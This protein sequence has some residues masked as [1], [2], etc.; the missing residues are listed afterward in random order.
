VGDRIGRYGQGGKAA[1]GHLGNLFDIVASAAGASAT[2]APARKSAPL[3]ALN[4]LVGEVELRHVPVTLN[5]ADVDRG[6]EA[7]AAVE[8]RLRALLAPAVRRFTREPAS[9]VTPEVERTAEQVRRIPARALRLLEEGRL[10]ESEV[11]AGC[12]GRGSGPDR[13]PGAGPAEAPKRQ[14]GLRR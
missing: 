5:K 12:A 3:M 9:A 4:R 1:I 13:R 7:W 8:S 2:P 11:S 6:S 14:A 10:F